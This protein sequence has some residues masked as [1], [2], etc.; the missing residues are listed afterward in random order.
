MKKEGLT[1]HE[2]GKSN[3]KVVIL[4]HPSMVYWDY[5]EDVIPFLEQKYHLLIPSIPGYDTQSTSDFTSIETIAEQIL[6]YLK[7]HKIKKVAAV[8]GCSMG[9]G[10]AL[11]MAA[12]QVINIENVIMDGGITPYQ[13][14]WIITRFI[15]IR[16]FA[17]LALG[18]LGGVKV[19][20]KAFTSENWEQEDLSYIVDVMKH[21]SYKTLW[22]T[23]DSCNNYKM[24]KHNIDLKANIYYWCAEKEFKERAWDIRYMRK[25][26][27]KT[28]FFRI[29]EI[30]HA[31][32][33]IK[34]PKR[35]AHE[36]MKVIMK[37]ENKYQ[38][39]LCKE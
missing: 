6:N 29:P 11:R 4:I 30:G 19:I 10:I 17:M 9:G 33:A 14:P 5:F 37:N 15:A 36:I 21:T 26:F 7:K 3:H 8:Y 1:V 35:F 28:Y 23:F 18:K 2:F 24:P 31:A 16:D 34:Q 39:T 13:L 12:K 32:F 22:R 38:K 20:A 27:P 25:F